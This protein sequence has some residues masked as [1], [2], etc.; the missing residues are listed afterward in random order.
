MSKLAGSATHHEGGCLCGAVRYRVEGELGAVGLCHCGQ[1]RRWT[2]HFLASTS[3]R[4]QDVTIE[5]ELRWYEST[6]GV[7]RRG[8]CPA[9]GSSLFWEAI[10]GPDLEI[11]A[12]TLD[13][14]TGL[15]TGHH[16]FV[17]DKGDYYDIA[18][19]LPQYQQGNGT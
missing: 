14:P 1:C 16:I 15:R 6:P 18:D 2:G 10:G 7:A 8:F 3:A 13:K 4:R 9:C 17:A 5:G 12:G 11:L 19:G